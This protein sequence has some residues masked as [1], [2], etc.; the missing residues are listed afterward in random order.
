MREKIAICEKKD[1]CQNDHFQD[2]RLKILIFKRS[3]NYGFSHTEVFSSQQR[4][5][6]KIS[7]LGDTHSNSSAFF[8]IET[9]YESFRY[10]LV[11]PLNLPILLKSPEWLI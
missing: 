4:V 2:F 3:Q 10:Y 11:L 6:L 5:K 9:V 8:Q 1:K 7:Y